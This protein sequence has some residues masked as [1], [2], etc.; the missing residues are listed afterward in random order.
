MLKAGLDGIRNNLQPPEPVEEN[1]YELDH[2]SRIDRKIDLLP[3]SLADAIE[4]LKNDQLLRDALGEHLFER[5]IDVK[6][7][8]WSE[9][10][11]QV[12]PWEL[13]TYLDIF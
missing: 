4:A 9:F 12:T 13:E 6:M 5:Y 7:R 10:K 1:I 8:E 3:T 11:Q 2:E